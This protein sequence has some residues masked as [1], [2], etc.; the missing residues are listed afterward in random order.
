M[1]AKAL[2]VDPRIV[3]WFAFLHDSQRVD[4]GIDEG[5]GARAADFAVQLRRDGAMTGLD[6]SAF[7]QLCEAMRLHSDGQTENEPAIRVCWDADRLDL[8]RVGTRP[9]P[10]YL[11]TDL[12]RREDTIAHAVSLTAA[13]RASRRRRRSSPGR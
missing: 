12:G 1:L 4:D 7:E 5:H 2:D 10:R 9:H 6:A 13:A 8:G 11:C 3:A